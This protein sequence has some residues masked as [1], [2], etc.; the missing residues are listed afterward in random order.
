MSTSYFFNRLMFYKPHG[1][2]TFTDS[3]T[4]VVP[5]NVTILKVCCIGGGVPVALISI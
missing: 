5:N 4:F 1:S 2:Q 3:G